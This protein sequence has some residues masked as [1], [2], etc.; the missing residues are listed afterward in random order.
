M[1]A[2]ITVVL[3]ILATFSDSLLIIQSSVR[4]IISRFRYMPLCILLLLSVTHPIYSF[5]IDSLVRL[6]GLHLA[7][8]AITLMF[9]FTLAGYRIGFRSVSEPS[10]LRGCLTV[11]WMDG[12][13]AVDTVMLI[14]QA[15]PSILI[16]SVGNLIGLSILTLCLPFVLRLFQRSAWFQN[17]V[18]GFMAYSASRQLAGEPVVSAIAG[19]LAL[20]LTGLFFVCM[21]GLYG[22]HRASRHR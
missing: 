20:H 7:S 6:P 8:A 21:V 22:W 1:S 15:S 17:I 4:D 2:T 14:A 10:L 11:L 19:G 5:V 13:M 12:L 3:I 9:A 18:A 16:T